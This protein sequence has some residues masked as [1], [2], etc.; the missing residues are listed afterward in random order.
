M[1][2]L[3]CHARLYLLNA[4]EKTKQRLMFQKRHQNN[5][6]SCI[7]KANVENRC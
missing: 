2:V 5:A 1:Y 6:C 7:V 4:K 3:H